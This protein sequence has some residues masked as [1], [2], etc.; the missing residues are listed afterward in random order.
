MNEIINR[1]VISHLMASHGFMVAAGVVLARIDT[2]ILFLLRFIP[3]EKLDS[4]I[5]AIDAA[6]KARIDKD[7]AQAQPANPPKS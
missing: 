7:A 3:K 1:F 2:I 4:A 6:A 5:D